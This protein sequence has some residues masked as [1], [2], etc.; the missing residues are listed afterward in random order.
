MAIGVKGIEK[1][2]SNPKV[3]LWYIPF[4]ALMGFAS[5]FATKYLS[6][7]P[8]P[9]YTVPGVAAVLLA[10]AWDSVMDHPDL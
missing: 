4:G 1:G 3:W 2:L 9:Q 10:V 6:F 7:L 8:F 5:T